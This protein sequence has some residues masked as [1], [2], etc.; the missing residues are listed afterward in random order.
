MGWNFIR[1]G[2]CPSLKIC[3]GVSSTLQKGAGGILS[4][5]Q[6]HGGVISAY[7]KM[8]RGILSGGYCPYP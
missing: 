5:L 2:L 4:Y 3:R 6:K 7:N 8:T 1:K